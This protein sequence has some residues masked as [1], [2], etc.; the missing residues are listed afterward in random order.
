LW[1]IN[2]IAI[3]IVTLIIS[4]FFLVD[5][6]DPQ[7]A[8]ILKKIPQNNAYHFSNEDYYTDILIKNVGGKVADF[9]QFDLFFGENAS[10]D[11]I[12]PSHNHS[13]IE[14]RVY[15]DRVFIKV[16]NI[17]SK[18]GIKSITG[19]QLDE[20]TIRVWVRSNTAPSWKILN[21]SVSPAGVFIDGDDRSMSAFE[22][23][24]IASL[25]LVVF[26]LVIVLVE[27]YY[28]QIH[29]RNLREFMQ[30]IDNLDYTKKNRIDELIK[31]TSLKPVKVE[32]RNGSYLLKW[33]VRARRYFLSFIWGYFIKDSDKTLILLMK[34]D[35]TIIKHFSY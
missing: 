1:L 19:L 17:F 29:R 23:F 3:T 11:S 6:L 4:H 24:F 26:L 2:A 7:P 15:S 27:L 20:I 9:V 21:S 16:N 5:L 18:N 28:N 25:V 14:H 34:K 12:M 8:I 31:Y 30:R 10:Y 22:I 13:S 35:G 33:D 32:D